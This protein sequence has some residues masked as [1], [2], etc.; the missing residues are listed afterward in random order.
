[1][2]RSNCLC[3]AVQWDAEGDLQFMSH[4]HCGRCRKAH[5]TAF[6]SAAAVAVKDLL[7]RGEENIERWR[8]PEGGVR[9]FCKQCGS[10][11]PADPWNGL[12]FLPAG[13]FEDD[14]GTRP[15]FHIFVGSK[16][17]WYEITDNLPRYDTYPQGVDAAVLP[18]SQPLDPPGGIRGSCLCGGVGFVVDGE[19]L[20]CHYCHC[21]RCRK[22]RSAAHAAN[23]F[24]TADGVHFTRGA[25]LLK[26]YK[27]PEAQFFTQV[28]CR[29]CGSK[30]PRI[31]KERGYGVIPL[32]ALDDDP[33]F[34]VQAH[35]FVG[36]KA[37]WFE[38]TGNV[39]QFAER[40]T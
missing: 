22:A 35:I 25:E 28:F 18:D 8:S 27:I 14:P 9:C 16:A 34:P 6:S 1:M 19:L 32:G 12:V 39:P 21:Q 11:T 5:G 10:A 36:S 13:N 37:P 40:V 33:H 31:D 17:P 15:Q 4:C 24:T 23:L 20:R 30:M 3:G 38:I 29:T 7:L 2:V 26:S